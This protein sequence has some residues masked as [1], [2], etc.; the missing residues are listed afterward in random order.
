MTQLELLAMAGGYL[1]ITLFAG[2]SRTT[3][4]ERMAQGKLAMPRIGPDR[5]EPR[6]GQAQELNAR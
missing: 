3:L 4:N 2:Q 6:H 1:V 5:T